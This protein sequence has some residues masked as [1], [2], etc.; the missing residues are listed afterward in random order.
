MP[1][2]ILERVH[3]LVNNYIIHLDG[4]QLTQ[5]TFD[6]IVRLLH[7]DKKVQAIKLFRASTE[8][9]VP[10][11]LKLDENKYQSF[12]TEKPRTFHSNFTTWVKKYEVSLATDEYHTHTIG[13][14]DAKDAVEFIALNSTHVFYT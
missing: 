14:K 6:E 9:H 3:L 12:E 8:Q 10:I 4:Q 5:A 2:S 1:L 11:L 7:C 13:L